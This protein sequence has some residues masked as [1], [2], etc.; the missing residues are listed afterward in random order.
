MPFEIT[1]PGGAHGH[2]VRGFRVRVTNT[3]AKD[4][5]CLAKLEEM[6]RSDGLPFENVFLPVGLK[7][8]HQNLQ[9]R[10]AGQ[11]KL[12]SGESKLIEVAY[13]D[14]GNPE[15]EIVLQYEAD[16]YCVPRADYSLG[17]RVYGAGKP[18]AGRYRLYVD[19][20]GFLSHTA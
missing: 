4:Y 17:L 2:V 1:D 12:R 16:T 14:E 3:G 20:R 18:A 5:E 11:F 6:T 19:A 10:A 8:Q 13:L 7:T 9:K 15:S